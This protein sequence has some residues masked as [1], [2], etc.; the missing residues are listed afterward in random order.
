MKTFTVTIRATITKTV[1]VDAQ[2]ED[3]AVESAFEQ[4]DTLNEGYVDT[5][6]DELIDVQDVTQ[7]RRKVA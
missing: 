1:E 2:H 5:R 7:F 6:C 3:E 4:F